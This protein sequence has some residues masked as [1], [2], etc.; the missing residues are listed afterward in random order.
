VF[1]GK[2]YVLW[3]AVKSWQKHIY[4]TPEDKTWIHD[5]LQWMYL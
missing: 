5:R 4:V 3:C 1:C 2:G